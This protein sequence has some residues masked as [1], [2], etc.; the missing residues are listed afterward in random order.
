MTNEEIAARLEETADLLELDPGANRYR[1]GAYREG[2]ATLRQVQE[3]VEDILAKS[4]QK[5]L[6]QLYG[7]G[8]GLAGSIRELVETGHLGLLDRLREEAEPERAFTTLPGVG[9]KLATRIHQ[10]LDVETLPELERAAHSGRLR[11]VAGIGSKLE[12][13]IQEALQAR[14]QRRPA[15]S[16]KPPVEEILDVDREYRERAAAGRL[17]RIAPRRFNLE[18]ETWLPV[19]NSHRGERRYTALFSNTALAHQLNKTRDWVVLYYALPGEPEEQ[20]TV[21]TE[22]SGQWAGR[23]MIRG[24]EQECLRFYELSERAAAA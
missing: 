8:E 19:L 24:R 6:R 10:Q 22:S 9:P 4:G 3:P 13:H 12:R 23:R 2:A 20:V 17:R 1:V 16:R 18:G 11:E 21:V 14:L 15:S 5:G 7:I